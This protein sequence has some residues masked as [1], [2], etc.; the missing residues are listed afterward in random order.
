MSH[1]IDVH[2]H[3]MGEVVFDFFAP[4]VPKGFPMTKWTPEAAIE[5]MDRH[6]ISTQILSLPFA[7]MADPSD[8][9]PTNLIRDLNEAYAGLIRD[10]P[11]RFGA[12]ASLP[13]GSTDNSLAEVAYALDELK[14]DGVVLTSNVG[15]NYFG[16]PFYEPILAELADREVPVFVHP[17]VCPNYGAVGF[18]RVPSIIE[19]P[20]DTARNITNAIFSGVFKRHPGL[21]LIVAH[22]GGALPTLGWR[23]EQHVG[24]GHAPDDADIDAQHVADV[25]RSLYYETALSGSPN[26]LLPTLEV[27]GFE[28]I[29]FGTDYGA[30]PETFISRNIDALTSSSALNPS[31]LRGV[32]CGNAQKMFPRLSSES[33][34]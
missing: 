27:T 24:I 22:C 9:G 19:F 30:A 16:Q 3:Y 31:Q 26:S 1:R 33:R 4:F 5:F 6:D 7:L 23:I 29:L 2:N 17:N 11:G 8:F 13:F 18:G 25:L 32:E 12:F 20:L 10:Y 14:L 15:G 21:K 34:V 28:N